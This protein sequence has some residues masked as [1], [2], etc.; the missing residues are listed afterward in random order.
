METS[1]K[2]RAREI[3][4]AFDLGPM[5]GRV[6]RLGSGH[7]HETLLSCLPDGRA[8]VHQ[9]LNTTIFRDP[10]RLMQNLSRISEHLRS[11][12][13]RQGVRDA[14]RRALRIV[15]CRTGN[16]LHYDPDGRP[17]RTFHYVERSVTHDVA[18]NARE[19]REAARAFGSFAVALA[20]LPGPKLAE[21][22]PHFH[23]LDWRRSDFCRV[24]EEDASGRAAHAPAEVER[25]LGL[26]ERVAQES[27][28][29]GADRVPSRLSHNDCKLNNVLLDETSG[30]ALCVI[31]L[32]TV[33]EW[34]L[35]CDFGEFVRT[36]SCPF[37]ED[38]DESLLAV[39]LAMLEAATAG[40]IAGASPLLSRA[41]LAALPL[42]GPRMALENALRFLGDYLAG[43]RY[44]RTEGPRQNL[45]RSRTQMRICELL[46]EAR[47]TTQRFI[48]RTPS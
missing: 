15:P 33:M 11:R 22:I 10:E 4:Q 48:D 45:V 16:L 9:R 8:F 14:D 21:T 19:V 31:D 17:W 36:S 29:C 6:E 18:T 13:A 47:D 34:S 44:F 26:F 41:E 20:D 27:R 40:Y 12:L 39:D 25:A 37:P 5:P 46:L 24:L 43:D 35:L 23:D 28:A 3:A 38:A 30:E 32:D 2:E 42:A 1:D 7:I